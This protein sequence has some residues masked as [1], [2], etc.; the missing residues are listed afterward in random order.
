MY[1]R[2]VLQVVT[3]PTPYDGGLIAISSYGIVGTNAHAVLQPGPITSEAQPVSELPVIVPLVGRSEE[4]VAESLRETLEHAHNPEYAYLLQRAYHRDIP[5]YSWRGFGM[6]KPGQ[7]EPSI[8]VES[9]STGG[10]RP[11][12]VIFP[13]MGSQWNEE[14]PYEDR[15]LFR[16]STK[17]QRN[18]EEP[19]PGSG[20]HV[21][22][23]QQNHL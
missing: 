11:V 20:R 7:S 15:T 14:R 8:M 16:V 2:H 19:W 12:C 10:D 4:Q 23:Q 13:G 5:G 22:P 18:N 3:E 1:S 9:C 21:G 17:V 6:L